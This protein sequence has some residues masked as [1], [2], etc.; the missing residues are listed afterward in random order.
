MP[1]I[2]E[3]YFAEIILFQ[4]QAEMLCH[5]IRTDQLSN[6]IKVNVFQILRTVAFSA[7]SALFGLFFSSEAAVP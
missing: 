4:H 2:V 1:Q 7:D 3:A 6:R 5:K